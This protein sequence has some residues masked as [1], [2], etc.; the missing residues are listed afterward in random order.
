VFRDRDIP[1]GKTWDEVI[2]EAVEAARCMLVL[3]SKNSVASAW[4]RAEAEEGL[5]RKILIP[6]L[7]EDA[8]IPLIFRPVQQDQGGGIPQS[9]KKCG[10]QQ[11]VGKHRLWRKSVSGNGQEA[12]RFEGERPKD[13]GIAR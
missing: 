5:Q 8:K 13:H 7:V 1:P 11:L 3:W 4:V 6:V 9:R 2:E 12:T 10:R